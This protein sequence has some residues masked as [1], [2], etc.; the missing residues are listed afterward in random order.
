MIHSTI[1]MVNPPK[2]DVSIIIVNMNGK[3]LLGDCLRSIQRE[4]LS[5]EVIVVDNASTDRSVDYLKKEFP[6]VH[7]IVNRSNFR[8]A[9]P[10]NDAMK[11]AKG[12]YYFILNNDTITQKG[13]LQ[14]LMDYL[15]R[16]DDVAMVGPQLLNKDGS[17]QRSCRHIFSLWTHFCDMSMIDK[18]FPHSVLFS[19]D[20]MSYFDHQMNQEVEHLMAAAVLVRAEAVKEVGMFDERLTI[21]INDMDWSRRFHLQGWKSVYISDAKVVHLGGQ[22]TKYFGIRYAIVKEMQLN[23]SWYFKKYY[24]FIGLIIFR[25]LQ[26]LGYLF[27]ILLRLVIYCV[28]PENKSKNHLLFSCYS[29]FIALF[30]WNIDSYQAFNT[31][32]I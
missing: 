31:D 12:K 23:L 24:G 5:M 29:F 25:L 6:D 8:F 18:L 7:V 11:L 21:F 19:G 10:N 2:Y 26:A 4:N 17:L 27:R 13:A 3:H 16:H 32:K 20:T 14:L 15:D 9:K 28:R 1:I 22:T 30:V